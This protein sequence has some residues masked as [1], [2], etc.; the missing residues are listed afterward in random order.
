MMQHTTQEQ[1]P[2]KRE[3]N[4]RVSARASRSSA[5]LQASRQLSKRKSA[6]LRKRSNAPAS[7]HSLAT[8]LSQL[9]AIILAIC[10][11][12]MW[13]FVLVVIAIVIGIAGPTRDYYV[14]QR[15]GEV[16][17]QKQESIEEKNAELE[18]ARER[19]M[20]EEG[21]QEEARKRGYVEPGE[22]GVSVEGLEKEPQSDPSKVSE[23]PDTRDTKTKVFDQ[24]F[25]FDPV[26]IW[27]KR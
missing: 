6:R 17:A 8:Q 25:G 27:N 11:H 19:L 5:S 12:R 2:H 10:T 14:A 9:I 3:Q 26:R 4:A 21:I 23:Y 7:E 22:I 15:T 13:V 1:K 20:T 24:L 16:L 18:H